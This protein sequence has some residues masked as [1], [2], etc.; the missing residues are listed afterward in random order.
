MSA[1]F[2]RIDL[3]FQADCVG[4]CA[5]QTVDQTL[6]RPSKKPFMSTATCTASLVGNINGSNSKETVNEMRSFVLNKCLSEFSHIKVLSFLKAFLKSLT[7]VRL[8]T[9]Y[10]ACEVLIERPRVI[11]V[12]NSKEENG[13]T[14]RSLPCCNNYALTKPLPTLSCLQQAN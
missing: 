6:D 12:Q 14:A 13:R 10:S 5:Y 1:P 3:Q 9:R 7:K 4:G 8:D 2:V 11:K